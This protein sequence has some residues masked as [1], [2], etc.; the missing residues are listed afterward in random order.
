MPPA[1]W[2][3]ALSTFAF[4][5]GALIFTG[6]LEQL[7]SDLGV[8]TAAA[9]QLQTA[10]VLTSA[11]SGPPLAFLSARLERR[12]V[13]M[14]ALVGAI[15]LNLLCM[16]SQS[17]ASLLILR[18][19]LGA[20]AALA[21]PAAA[22]AAGALAPPERRGAAMALVGGGMTL[23]FLMGIPLGTV[24]G[25]AFG[26]RAAFA[27]S[28]G[29]AALALA[30]IALALP[31]VPAGPAPTGARA[32]PLALAPLY[33]ATFLSFAGNMTITTYIAPILRLQT[34]V[35]GSGVALFQM[36]VGLG[37]LCGLNLGA[38][39][40]DS[41]R[42]RLGVALAFM[43]LALAALMHLTE[44]VG[45]APAG[46]PTYVVVAATLF[47]GSTALFSIMPVVQSRL[48]AAAPAA[49]AF[50]LSINQSG[51]SLGQA[52][53]GALGGL[54]L[55]L[56]DARALPVAAAAI[57]LAAGLIWLRFS[58]PASRQGA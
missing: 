17:L 33:A 3:L 47:L 45:G 27:L 58:G 5:S 24:V 6:L 9:G 50:A 19:I 49:A 21:G 57:A 22:S 12:S 56:F 51:A 32:S 39:A 29:L 25:S 26:W 15:V 41:R 52:S 38:R 28:A 40:A 54:L 42:G 36:M 14:G 34:G 37:S 53:G 44:L 10:Y 18:C 20:T 7:A 43:G 35:T 23:A 2:I 30:G 31:R 8:S 55:G 48:V 46:W 1:V 11:L 16:A 4:G 13:L